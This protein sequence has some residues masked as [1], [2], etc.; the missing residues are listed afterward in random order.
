MG[1]G[2]KEARS[3]RIHS[4]SCGIKW[5]SQG[6]RPTPTLA[7]LLVHLVLTGLSLYPHGISFSRSRKA[8]ASH[9]VVVSRWLYPSVTAASKRGRL[10]KVPIK[11]VL[12][13]CELIT[14]PVQIQKV[15]KWTPLPDEKGGQGHLTEDHM[16]PFSRPSWKMQ[17]AVDGWQNACRQCGRWSTGWFCTL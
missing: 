13:Y 5:D 6:W 11:R 16:G 10:W 1:L 15:K 7:S 14:R 8:V 17:P 2:F 9:C 3:W 12:P 4:Y